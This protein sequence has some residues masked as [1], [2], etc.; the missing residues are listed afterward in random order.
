MINFVDSVPRYWGYH[1]KGG[2]T[3]V[4][5]GRIGPAR[6]SQILTNRKMWGRKSRGVNLAR[7]T[8]GRLRWIG[9]YGGYDG[10]A[11]RF[12]CKQYRDGITFGAY[13]GTMRAM[14]GVKGRKE[15]KKVTGCCSARNPDQVCNAPDR[16][17]D[18][19]KLCKAMGYTRGR[20]LRR[21]NK[22]TCP[23]AKF[24]KG[25]WTS[26]FV[27]TPGYGQVFE[28][29][30][31]ATKSLYTNKNYYKQAEPKAGQPKQWDLTMQWRGGRYLFH[32]L[33]IEGR[34]FSGYRGWISKCPRVNRRWAF[35]PRIGAYR[36]GKTYIKD[37]RVYQGNSLRKMRQVVGEGIGRAAKLR[38]QQ[39]LRAAMRAARNM[40]TCSARVG[41]SS[42][43]MQ[44][45]GHG[46]Y[47]NKH[48]RD[49]RRAWTSWAITHNAKSIK[50][51]A[52]GR[53]YQ[54]VM[55]GLTYRTRPDVH[56]HHGLRIGLWTHQRLYVW[57]MGWQ[58]RWRVGETFEV[59]VV[60]RVNYCY[61]RN[62]RRIRC[63]RK[64]PNHIPRGRATAQVWFHER[65]NGIKIEKVCKVRR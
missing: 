17:Y 19:H 29:K 13:K 12:F 20:L 14:L 37:L 55:F 43:N 52:I 46:R 22:N 54:H 10:K 5:R 49:R 38:K 2:W 15:P 61:Y 9:M 33:K 42:S 50:V 18:V 30:G 28:C 41:W 27:N 65:G 11:A 47:M 34:D 4:K 63:W 57:G 58:G 64:H 60:G 24:H 56:F 3:G 1:L 7:Y 21:S 59:R 32:S 39:L 62:N 35:A 16:H 53:A 23:E 40:A 26:D 31:A 25:K 51:R 6:C 44:F 45:W 8:N 36:N 48:A